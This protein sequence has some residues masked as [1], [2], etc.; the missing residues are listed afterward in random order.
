MDNEK[1]ENLMF[2][3]ILHFKFIS[4]PKTLQLW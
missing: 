2:D 1:I 3:L 4:N